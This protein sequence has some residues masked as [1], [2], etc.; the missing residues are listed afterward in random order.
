[1]VKMSISEVQALL[2]AEKSDALGAMEASELSDQRSK[3]MEYYLGDPDLDG[4]MPA[5]AD[6]SKAVSSD[7]ADTVEGLMP[8]LMEI[9]ASGDDV[10]EFTPVGEEDEDAAQQET[11]YV[12]HQFWHRNHGFLTLY[13]FFKDALLQKNGIVKVWWDKGSKEERET[14]YDLD[15]DSY[16]MLIASPEVEEIAHTERPDEEIPAE[17]QAPDAMSSGVPQSPMAGMLAAPGGMSAQPPAS[18]LP[19]MMGGQPEMGGVGQPAMPAPM[20]RMLHDVTVVKRTDYAFCHV[21]P[22]PPEEFGVSR[23]ARSV[24]IEDS[25]Y[26]FHETRTTQQALID[27]G[28]DEDQVTSLSTSRGGADTE[29]AISRDTV[30]DNKDLAMASLN[31]ATRLIWVTEHYATLDYEKKG[32]SCLYKIKTAGGTNEILRKDGK[33]DIEPFDAMPFVSTTP[34]I[35]PHRFFGRSMADLV[36]DIMRIKTALLRSGLDNIYL[37][38]NQRIEIS[39]QHS[40][41]RTL[42]DLLTNRPGGIVRTKT[43]GGLNVIPNQSIGDV[44][45]PMLEYQDAVREWRTGVTRQGQGIDAKSLAN[46]SATAAG[47]MFSMAQARMRLIARI[48]A[49]TGVRDLFKLMHATIRKHGRNQQDTVRLRNKWVQVDP[50]TWKTRNDMTIDVANVSGSKDQQMVFMMTLLGIQKEAIMAPQMG[51]VKPGNIYNTLKRI[52]RLSGQKGVEPFFTDPDE[53]GPDGKP[54]NQAPPP[55][56]PKAEIEKAK[57]EASVAEGQAKMQMDQQ[58]NAAQLQNDQAKGAAQL[59]MEREK[60]IAQ[61]QTDRERAAADLQLQRE[62]ITMEHQLKQEQMVAE[63]ALKREQLAAELQLKRELSMYEMQHRAQ[64]E[65]AKAHIGAAVSEVNVGGQPG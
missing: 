12:N 11:D 39:E 41:D 44:V 45:Y 43:P 34:I 10:V 46:Q 9:F 2:E 20:P 54:V 33:P 4:D 60:A 1:M 37:A 27:E 35:M 64:T 5:P 14:Y 25:D 17:T 36:M 40:T 31:E 42:D 57:L 16:A 18:A 30:E 49:E 56:D 58:K 53:M 22:V 28:Y 61:Q 7:V 15:D 52:V 29:E 47:Q 59:Q 13:S 32:K 63:M 48:F 8:S 65:V 62:K 21:E 55:P 3:A 24:H 6:R 38:N 26:C 23:R 50:R 19:P 51:L